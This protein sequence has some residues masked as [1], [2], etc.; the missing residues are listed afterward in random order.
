[1]F[2]CF[3]PYGRTAETWTPRIL[4]SCVTLG[5][6]VFRASAPKTTDNRQAT[7]TSTLIWASRAGTLS[8]LQ[9]NLRKTR[10]LSC[11]ATQQTSL[12]WVAFHSGSL[13]CCNF[14]SRC[15][16][17]VLLWRHERPRER[18]RHRILL[19][20]CLNCVCVCMYVC[21]YVCTYVCTY[22]CMYVCVLL[23]LRK[24]YTNTHARTHTHT[25]THTHIYIY[26]YMC[27][28]VCVCV[29]V[30]VWRLLEDCALV[31][32][33]TFLSNMNAFDTFVLTD[34]SSIFGHPDG[35]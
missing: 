21:I 24:F 18:L 1:M 10:K 7:A 34:I 23:F 32:T 5:C 19:S 27:V 30:R 9:R 31:H 13:V 16:L 26:I 25:H 12:L 3:L 11:Q 2:W 15:E 4:Q 20:H 35:M 6:A 29:C 28:C 8:K 33:V 22:V 14:A 17:F